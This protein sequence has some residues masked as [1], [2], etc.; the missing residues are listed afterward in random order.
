MPNLKIIPS[1]G[2]LNISIKTTFLD[3]T[4]LK[5]KSEL[6]SINEIEGVLNS[7]QIKHK[8]EEQE[9]IAQEDAIL[10]DVEIEKVIDQQNQLK[11][12]QQ[13]LDETGKL[14]LQSIY[15][16]GCFIWGN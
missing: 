4:E 13:I 7:S 8:K 2:K 9:M 15:C 1:E 5:Q 12:E 11:I 6:H 10:K 3:Q 16:R 14:N